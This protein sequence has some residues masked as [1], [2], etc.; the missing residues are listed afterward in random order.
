[1]SKQVTEFSA[2]SNAA[3][4]DFDA[5]SSLASTDV[6]AFEKAKRDLLMQAVA[7]APESQRAAL[8]ALV[9]QLMAPVENATG[10]DRAVA[11]HNMMM[12]SMHYLQGEMLSLK[13]Y[14]GDAPQGAEIEASMNQFITLTTTPR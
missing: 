1:M 4:F 2:G 11:A 8:T 5:W 3:G 9:E 13:S 14:V 6:D 10:L 12:Q 7:E